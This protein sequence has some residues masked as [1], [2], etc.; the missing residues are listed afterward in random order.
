MKSGFIRESDSE[1][2]S[3]SFIIP[4]KD[5]TALPCWVCNYQQLNDNTV[6]DNFT[7]P[8]VDNILAN[9]GKGKMWAVFDMT[10]SFYQ[11]RMHPDDIHKTAVTTP[12]GNYEWLVLP[13]GFRNAPSIHQRRVAS[14]LAPLIRKICHVY[15]DDIIIW[16]QNEQEHID[17]CR[18]VM[19]LLSKARLYLNKRKTQLFCSEVTFLGHKISQAGIEA[20][21]DKVSKILDWPRPKSATD[22]RR[23]LGLTCYIASF[24]PHLTVHTRVLNSLTSKECECNFPAWND[25][26]DNAF[27]GVKDIVVSRECLMVIDYD[28]LNE[29][30]IFI[31]M[32]A[33]DTVS[34]AVLSFGESWE[35]ARPVAFDSAP[36]KDAEL[37]YP[38]HEKELLAVMRALR[39]WKT[40][41]LGVPVYIMTDHHTLLNFNTQRN[42]SR[43]QTHWMEEISIYDT[44]FV[45]IKGTDNTVANALSCYPYLVAESVGD[46]IKVAQEAFPS[47]MTLLL[48]R[49]TQN[50][51]MTLSQVCVHW[52]ISQSKKMHL[53]CACRCLLMKN[54][55]SQSKMGTTLTHGAKS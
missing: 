35:S 46:A 26:Y 25:D 18:K 11:T 38:V 53:L 32:D 49:L 14:A 3:P 13:M 9:C 37:R 39:K 28:N 44:N 24:L 42:L 16:S 4:K 23:F 43:R 8:R 7:L 2:A 10:D 27:Q 30:K 31:T 51:S 17:N 40:D 19:D 36:F 54:S 48:R 6:P 22:V 50:C 15:M 12:F 34:G 52:S 20:D 1:F 33:S 29:N 47:T 41:V 55:W 5:L 45:Y 21:S